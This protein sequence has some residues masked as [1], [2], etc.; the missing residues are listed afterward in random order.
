MGIQVRRLRTMAAVLTLAAVAVPAVPAAAQDP[1]LAGSTVTVWTMEDAA[2]VQGAGQALRGIDGGRGRRRGGP[3]GRHRREA[4]DGRRLGQRTGRHPDRPVAA[5]D[6]QRGRRAGGPCAVPRRAPGPRQRQLPRGGL[7]RQSQQRR[8]GHERALG[9]G[10][11]R[12]VL[13]HRHLRRG[14]AL[15]PADHLGGVHRGRPAARDA[16]RG[17]LRLLHPAVGRAAAHPVHV[18]GRR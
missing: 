14:R 9:R 5:A 18:A 2:A 17:P 1:A 6:V 16:R 10:H 12:P 8:H 4:D 3:L 11:P 13:P 7:R 15:R